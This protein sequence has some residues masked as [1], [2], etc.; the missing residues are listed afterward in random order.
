MLLSMVVGRIMSYIPTKSELQKL[1][2][3]LKKIEFFE[4][5]TRPLGF[6]FWEADLSGYDKHYK[7][8][9]G[10]KF[11]Y[12]ILLSRGKYETQY[13]NRKQHDE[14]IRSLQGKLKDYDFLAHHERILR[15]IYQKLWKL[16]SA[17][18][19]RDWEAATDE[20]IVQWY[21]EY[22]T[23]F[24]RFI[25]AIST[26][27]LMMEAMANDLKEKIAALASARNISENIDLTVR[28]L[29]TPEQLSMTAQEELEFLKLLQR[30]GGHDFG[31][32]MAAHA[33]KWAYI[34][35]YAQ[36]S[37]WTLQDY[38]KR[39]RA[40][41]SKEIKRKYQELARHHLTV[42]NAKREIYKKL[43]VSAEIKKRATLLSKFL[44]WRINDETTIGLLTHS[45]QKII[46]EI[47]KRLFVAPQQLAHMSGS[48][49]LTAMRTKKV[50]TEIANERIKGYAIVINPGGVAVISGASLARVLANV[51]LKKV[52]EKRAAHMQG[53]PANPGKVSGRVRIILDPDLISKVKRGDILVTTQTTPAYVAGMK[54]A[55]A[56]IAEEGGITSHAAIVSR[57]LGVPC[58]IGVPDVTRV[59]KDGDQ[60]EVDATK[61]TVKK[62]K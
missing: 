18:H 43:R 48:E 41:D 46:A 3:D 4:W 11:K 17:L 59:L 30:R 55:G 42:E 54:I 10:K 2:S 25:G 37:P 39:M 57:E 12:V 1:I 36:F 33:K 5:A 53:T 51:T 13:R 47:C 14:F 31:K 32:R 61:G 19:A 62:M 38:K 52:A 28:A 44:F 27:I 49:I 60:V 7:E 8:F 20:E 16:A 15:K 45:R 58:V 56:I 34:P 29:S 9:I 6:H 23:Q 24:A 40:L 35:V 21:R 22:Y 26:G 50:N